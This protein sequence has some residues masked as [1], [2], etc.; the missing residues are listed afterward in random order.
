M[1]HINFNEEVYRVQVQG[2]CVGEVCYCECRVRVVYGVITLISM[3]AHG[4]P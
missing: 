3:V 1:R 2:G 4:D